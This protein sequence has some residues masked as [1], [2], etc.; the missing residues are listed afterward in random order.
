MNAFR[1][2]VLFVGIQLAK[3]CLERHHFIQNFLTIF[4]DSFHAWWFMLVLSNITCLIFHLNSDDLVFGIALVIIFDFMVIIPRKRRDAVDIVRAIVTH[5]MAFTAT[6]WEINVWW[7]VFF[8]LT[9]LPYIAAMSH[10]L[11]G[12]VVWICF[13]YV[14]ADTSQPPRRRRKI[15]IRRSVSVPLREPAIT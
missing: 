9:S 6:I 4:M 10:N 15:R 3:S 14:V 13:S 5:R 11:M 12:L 1:K 2:A 7:Y 8:F